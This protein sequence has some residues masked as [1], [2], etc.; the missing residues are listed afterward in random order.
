[1]KRTFRKWMAA[2]LILM[3]CTG[4]GNAPAEENSRTID[5]PMAGIRIDISAV[6][7]ET[8]GV[9]GTDG[10]MELASGS[11]I[12]YSYLFY[13]AAPR[14]EF[15][16]LYTENPGALSSRAAAICYLFTVGGGL[17]FATMVQL[18]GI[19][20]AAE[21][22]VQVGQAGG[23]TFYLYMSGSPEFAASVGEA[24]GAEYTALCG[25][26]E[27]IATGLTCYAPV[28]E[29]TASLEGTVIR[30]EGTDPE[31]NP[32]SS[33]EL[34]AKHEITMVNIWATW[35]GPCVSELQELQAIHLRFLEKDCAVVGLMTD[36]NTEEAKRLIQANG[37]TYDIVLAPDNFNSIVPF[38]SIPTTFFVDRNGTY[39]GPKIVG[40][41]PQ[42]YEATMES[43]LNGEKQ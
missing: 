2:L 25:M 34:F 16:R 26:G 32:V 21:N 19:R 20:F 6:F 38:T 4:C 41:H 3:I 29:Y 5:L 35:C 43:L 31:G 8:K 30:F 37:M 9:I 1:M 7:G 23:Y 42:Q 13:C 24:Y 28:N 14:E 36:R 17:D 39:L 11:N 33:E 10:A 15:D 22:A 40:A 27:E 18:T 12:F